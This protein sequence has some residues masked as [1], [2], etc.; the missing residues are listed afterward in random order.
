MAPA[1]EPLATGVFSEALLEEALAAGV[2][3]DVSCGVRTGAL[4]AAVRFL[5][6]S[7]CDASTRGR[8]ARAPEAA[9]AL[10]KLGVGSLRFREL[11]ASGSFSGILAKRGAGLFDVAATEESGVLLLI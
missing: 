8:T 11:S 6:G 10:A 5:G 1:W 2:S 3:R 7:A 4:L 9:V